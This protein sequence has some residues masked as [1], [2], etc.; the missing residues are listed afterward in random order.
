MSFNT[1][2]K[3]LQQ[4]V[5]RISALH[6]LP[7][8]VNLPVLWGRYFLAAVVMLLTITISAQSPQR[9]KMKDFIGINT[10]ITDPMKYTTK[11]QS[12]R[13]YHL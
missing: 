12:V 9:P 2:A 11:F 13:E 3:V 8:L 6:L 4:P 7:P 1:H 5:A 10:R